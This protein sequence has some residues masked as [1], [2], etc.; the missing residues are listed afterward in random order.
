MG[1]AIFA[2]L[3]SCCV[4]AFGIMAVFHRLENGSLQRLIDDNDYVL[5]PIGLTMLLC[6]LWFV[7]SA[8]GA[9]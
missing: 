1:H 7:A 3:V 5:I 4:I 9:I 8:L 6:F 2:L